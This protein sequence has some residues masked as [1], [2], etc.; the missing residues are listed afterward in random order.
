MTLQELE[1]ILSRHDKVAAEYGIGD[2]HGAS[3]VVVR[4]RP[5]TGEKIKTPFGLCPILNC[6][7]KEGKYQTCFA[8]S[9]KQLVTMIC[10]LK[11]TLSTGGSSNG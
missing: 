6:Q 1:E 4:D 8:V 7:E 5:P 3:L 11:A 9:R 2:H 10:K